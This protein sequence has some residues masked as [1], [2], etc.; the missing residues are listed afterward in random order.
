MELNPTHV[1]AERISRSKASIIRLA[2]GGKYIPIRLENFALWGMGYEPEPHARAVICTDGS[3]D[4]NA[5]GEKSGGGLAYI[6]DGFKE[7]EYRS[8]TEHWRI[9]TQNN[10]HAELSAINRALRTVPVSV[11][12]TKHTDSES[13]LKVINRYLEAGGSPDIYCEGRPYIRMILRAIRARSTQGAKTLIEH[14]RSHTGHRNIPSMGNEAADR[15]ATRGRLEDGNKE[16]DIDM[17]QNELKYLV[18]LEK[19]SEG[20]EESKWEP[21][22]GNVRKAVKE[23]LLKAQMAEWGGR[24]TRGKFA[25]E[26]PKEVRGI[27]KQIWKAPSTTKIT[28]LIDVLNRADPAEYD[29]GQSQVEV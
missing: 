12:L 29:N 8:R 4:P 25:R 11:D 2:F 3:T 16:V 18:L 1:D 27:I 21:I 13:A 6:H 14:V 7:D 10:Y 17:F 28:F 22:H 9:G 26:H 5:P 19:D 20:D 24:P 15:A 23:R